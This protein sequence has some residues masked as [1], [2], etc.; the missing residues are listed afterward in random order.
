MWLQRKR[1]KAQ[2]AI[3]ELTTTKKNP[4]KVIGEQ[5]LLLGKKGRGA[6]VQKH[7]LRQLK[8]PNNARE[9]ETLNKAVKQGH[10]TQNIKR[11]KEQPKTLHPI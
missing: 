2:K 8:I 10:S 11:N 6:K 4:T 5:V 3:G 7:Y 9:Y 1:Q